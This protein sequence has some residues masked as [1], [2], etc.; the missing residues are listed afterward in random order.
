[1]TKVTARKVLIDEDPNQVSLNRIFIK[2]FSVVGMKDLEI[3][4]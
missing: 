1:M 2:I 3:R 4:L